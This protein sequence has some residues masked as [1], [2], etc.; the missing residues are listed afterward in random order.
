MLSIGSHP[1]KRTQPRYKTPLPACAD[2]MLIG[3]TRSCGI[4]VACTDL[5]ELLPSAR[6]TP[7]VQ[8]KAPGLPR[9]RSLPICMPSAATTDKVASELGIVEQQCRLSV[10]STQ[11]AA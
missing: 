2:I 5:Q 7:A 4:N 1:H 6:Q 9:S 10:E 11:I 8:L 3:K